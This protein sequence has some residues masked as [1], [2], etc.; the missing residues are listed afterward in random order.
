MENKKK[1]I[2]AVS[3]LSLLG[4][5]LV[6]G[7]AA[8]N[9]VNEVFNMNV[10]AAQ[11]PVDFTNATITRRIYLV[12][13]DPGW[14]QVNN[15][16]IFIHAYQTSN[17][18]HS[19][20][21][22]AMTKIYND[23]HDGGLF[24]VDV[25]FEGA[26]DAISVVAKWGEKGTPYGAANNNQT[27]TVELPSLASKAG[28]VLYISSGTT[29]D[30]SY[31]NRNASKGTAGGTSGF[32]AVVMEHILT[33]DASYAKGYNA[34]PQLNAD[35]LAPSKT[36]IDSYGEGTMVDDYDYDAYVLNDKSYTG[37]SKTDDYVNLK[38]KIAGLKDQYDAN[39]W[40]VA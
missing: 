24:Y 26:G 38:Q 20:D 10:R 12:D 2:V 31:N 16:Q 29:W 28:D 7:I 39:G 33:C 37:M 14:W 17:D 5:G 15:K 22:G 4:V 1:A 23:Y 18:A 9:N 34:Y 11:T 21:S 36:E 13:T 35:F 30:G 8:N 19:F 32:V 6:L 40:Y 25:T 27:V 3:C